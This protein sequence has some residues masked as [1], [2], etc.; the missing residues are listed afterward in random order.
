MPL[1]PISNGDTGRGGVLIDE[2]VADVQ[3]EARNQQQAQ[4]QPGSLSLSEV[5]FDFFRQQR[6]L[7]SRAARL[8]VD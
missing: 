4:P 6:L 7:A 3:P 1:I 8:R 2:V 5:E